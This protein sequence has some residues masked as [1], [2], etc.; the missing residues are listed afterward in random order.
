[1]VIVEKEK[2]FSAGMELPKEEKK[3]RTS[4]QRKDRKTEQ[5]KD[6]TIDKKNNVKTSFYIDR[7]Q[8]LRL[9]ELVIQFKKKGIRKSKSE[10]MREGIE[11]IIEKYKK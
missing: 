8:D 9:D 10:L 2:V 1:M 7:E 4:P 5:Q 11:I 3:K 6:R